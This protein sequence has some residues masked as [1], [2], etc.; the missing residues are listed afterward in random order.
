L[1]ISQKRNHWDGAIEA[2][3]WIVTPQIVTS[4]AVTS[5]VG[6]NKFVSC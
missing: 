6:P 5:I 1:R 4:S 2:G 3:R